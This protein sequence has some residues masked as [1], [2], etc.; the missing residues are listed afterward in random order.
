MILYLDTSAFLKLYL[1]EP[2]SRQVRHAIARAKVICTHLIAYAEMRAGLA[3][4]VRMNRVPA[5]GLSHVIS[6]FEA[7]WLNMELVVVDE[8]LVRRAGDLAERFGL[9]GYNSVHLAVAERVWQRA[10][11]SFRLVAFDQRLLDAGRA[12]GMADLEH[13]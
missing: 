13:A 12:V 1:K 3:Q 5:S 6:R 4:A 2:E 9:R 11:G 8:P 7:D 10:P